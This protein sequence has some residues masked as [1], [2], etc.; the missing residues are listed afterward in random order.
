MVLGPADTLDGKYT[1]FGR[2]VDGIEV[3]EAMEVV[4]LEG[5]TP[6]KRIEVTR[7]RVVPAPSASA[8]AK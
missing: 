5:E 6:V 8:G 1:A 3:V 4:T 2:V 7:A